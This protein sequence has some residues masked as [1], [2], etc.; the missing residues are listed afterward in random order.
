M[1]MHV[2]IHSSKPSQKKKKGVAL[3]TRLTLWTGRLNSKF[4]TQDKTRC[5]VWN[6]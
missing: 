6:L 4:P 1:K 5:T 2:L 3:N